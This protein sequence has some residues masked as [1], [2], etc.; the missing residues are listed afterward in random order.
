MTRVQKLTLGGLSVI[1]CS[2]WLAFLAFASQG[3]QSW[4]QQPLGPTLGYPTPWQLPATWTASPAAS[5][6]TASATLSPTLTLQTDTPVSPFLACNNNLPTMTVL[7]IGTDVRPGEHRYGLTDVMRAVRVDF[8]AQRVTALEFPR[9]LWV[10]IPEIKHNLKTD[11][12]KLNTAYAYGQPDYGP[13]LLAHTLNLNFGLNVDHYIVANMNVFAEVVDALGGLDVM[14]PE[15]GIDGRTSTDRSARLVFPG[16]PQ[17]LNGEQALTLARLRNVSVFERA[18]HQNMVMCALRKRVESPETI[19]RVPAIINS[20]M[21]NIQTDLTPEQIS[22]L[23]CLGTQ[24]PRGNILFTSFPLKLFKSAKV[25][26][27]VLEQD[28]FI[29][30]ANFDTLRSYVSK[31]QEGSWPSSS[32]S[33]ASEPETS[34]CE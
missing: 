3:V 16:G 6:P 13:S 21:S 33:E 26:D 25:Y 2:V 4:R 1:A 7:A 27:S 15:G 31:F 19:L 10:K 11:H 12:Q 24:M 8:R 9:D 22:Q 28:V 29:W 34:Y 32:L 23:A 14:L 30:A 5:Q 18:K 20:F 17:H